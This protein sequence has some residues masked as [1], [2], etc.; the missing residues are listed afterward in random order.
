MSNDYKFK[1]ILNTVNGIELIL[2]SIGTY[3]L[4]KYKYYIHHMISMFIYFS[5]GVTIDLIIRSFTEIHYNY[6]YIYIIYMLNDVT[7]FCY[8]KY[9]MDKLYYNYKEVVLY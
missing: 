9:M 6:V 2:M 3:I 5:L 4:L 1:K 7:V 8:L